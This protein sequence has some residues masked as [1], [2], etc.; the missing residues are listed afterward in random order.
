[1]VRDLLHSRVV[2][3]ARAGMIL[4]LSLCV[5]T[6]SGKPRASGDDPVPLLWARLLVT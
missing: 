3:P 4:M 1:M 5:S 6:R 2:N